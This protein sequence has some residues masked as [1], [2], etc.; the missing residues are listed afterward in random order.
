MDLRARRDVC[1]EA[2]PLQREQAHSVSTAASPAGSYDLMDI[3]YRCPTHGKV[4][5]GDGN[6]AGLTC[7]L[8]IQRTAAGEVIVERCGEPLTR[9]FD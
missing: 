7:A 1:V 5:P 9:Y 3:E 6:G 2:I 8:M 4:E